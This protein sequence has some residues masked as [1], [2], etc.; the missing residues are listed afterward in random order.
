MIAVTIEIDVLGLGTNVKPLV[1]IA[2][3]NDGT[4]TP[5]RGNY[6]Y[7]ISH[8]DGYRG[9]ALPKPID[10]L[11]DDKLP[12]KK[13]EIRNFRRQSGAAALLARVMKDAFS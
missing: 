10:L 6:Y 13:G 4:G 11:R 3:A 1:V 5:E 12:W 9:H 8:Q 2:I 7:R